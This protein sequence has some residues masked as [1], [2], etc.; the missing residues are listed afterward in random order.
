MP[1]LGIGA[2]SKGRGFKSYSPRASSKVT[3]IVGK[4]TFF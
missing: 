2:Q 4:S 3:K 1:T